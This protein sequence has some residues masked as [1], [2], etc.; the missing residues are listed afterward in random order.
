MLH[1]A[2]KGDSFSINTEYGIYPN[3]ADR[4]LS[5]AERKLELEQ[6]QNEMR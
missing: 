2:T 5:E 3:L 4:T 1:L 6:L